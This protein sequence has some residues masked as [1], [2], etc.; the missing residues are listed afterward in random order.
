MKRILIGT[1]NKGKIDELVSVFKDLQK[2]G[3]ELVTLENMLKLMKP[4]ETGATFE[5]NAKLKAQ[6]YSNKTG[7]PAIADDGGLMIDILN[8]E[9]GVKS[10]R[11][12]GFEAT[13]EELIE[14]A[15]EKLQGIPVEKR[16]ARLETCLCFYDFDKQIFLTESES[17]EGWISEEPCPIVTP[18]Y[19]YRA[20]FMVKEFNKFYDEL[21]EEE[22]AQVNHRIKAAKRLLLKIEQDLLGNN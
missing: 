11:W 14:F 21:T 20:L 7:L 9:P 10:R 12:R 13:D 3:I 6:F 8:G 2:Y 5:E 1:T 15:L 17:I 18:G 16:T 19:P 22:H 4:E